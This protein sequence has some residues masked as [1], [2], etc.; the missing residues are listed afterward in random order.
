ML[1]FC[2]RRGK[3]VSDRELII[4]DGS[5]DVKHVECGQCGLNCPARR[6]PSKPASRMDVI[7]AAEKKGW[8]TNLNS[9]RLA[10]ITPDCVIFNSHDTPG[11]WLTEDDAGRLDSND[12]MVDW[13]IAYK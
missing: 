3:L 5:G 1:H 9:R 13:I 4:S 8:K 12:A 2:D 7:R 10:V 6:F 11:V